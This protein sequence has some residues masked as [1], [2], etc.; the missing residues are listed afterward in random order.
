MNRVLASLPYIA[1]A[2]RRAIVAGLSFAVLTVPAVSEASPVTYVYFGSVTSTFNGALVPLGSPATISL[3]V[4]PAANV[5]AGNTGCGNVQHPQGGAYAFNLVMDFTG[6]EYTTS[7][8]FET[9]YDFYFCMPQPGV[10]QVQFPGG[11]QGPPLNGVVPPTCCDFSFTPY[12]PA[13]TGSLAPCQSI[14]INVAFCRNAFLGGSSPT[15]PAL[16][17]FPFFS[18]QLDFRGDCSLVDCPGGGLVRV[19]GTLV[20]EPAT[21]LLLATGLA[22]VAARRRSQSRL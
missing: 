22:A 6:R 20:P 10:T 5:W 18:Y 12:A 2:S 21:L 16:P 11:L 19:S 9:N 15:S 13:M 14:N 17:V 3:T 1:F 4:D 7:G 8:Y